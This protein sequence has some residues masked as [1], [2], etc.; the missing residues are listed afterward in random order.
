MLLPT[1]K[2]YDAGFVVREYGAVGSQSFAKH[3]TG[4]LSDAVV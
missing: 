3:S 1:I 4:K 2:S